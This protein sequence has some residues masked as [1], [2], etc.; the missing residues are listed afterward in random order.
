MRGFFFIYPMKINGIHRGIT[1][2]RQ[3]LVRPLI[4]FISGLLCADFLADYASFLEYV[5]L[6]LLSILFAQSHLQFLNKT[7]VSCT[8]YASFFLLGVFVNASP[9]PSGSDIPEFKNYTLIIKQCSEAVYKGSGDELKSQFT[10]EA[11][12]ILIDKTWQAVDGIIKFTLKND[13]LT[14][15][16][17]DLLLVHA[18]FKKPTTEILPGS[19]DSER[20]CRIKSIDALCTLNKY[21]LIPLAKN[22]QHFVFAFILNLRRAIIRYLKTS[23]FDSNQVG[24]ASALLVGYRADID[25][26]LNNAYSKA[27]IIHVLAVSGMHVSLVFGSVLWLLGRFLKPRNAAIAGILVLWFYALLAGLSASVLRSACMFSLLAISK[28]LVK[29]AITSNAMAGAA[30]IMLI[31]DPQTLYDPGAQLSF[32]AVWGIYARATP[33]PILFFKRKFIRYVID[34]L[35]IC[36]VAQLATLPITFWYFG[37]F[38]VYFLLANLVAVPFS[39][40]LIYLGFISLILFPLGFVSQQLLELMKIGIDILNYFTLQIAGLPLSSID[41]GRFTFIEVLFSGCIIYTM[42]FPMGSLIKK[43]YA[44]GIARLIYSATIIL[45]SIRIDKGPDLY[46]F[47]CERTYHFVSVGTRSVRLINIGSEQCHTCNRT[48]GIKQFAQ[49][50]GRDLK[51]ENHTIHNLEDGGKASITYIFDNTVHTL[52]LQIYSTCNL[53]NLPSTDKSSHAYCRQFN[54]SQKI[55]FLYS[56]ILRRRVLPI[57]FL[58][59]YKIR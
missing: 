45:T 57:G 47:S 10:A 32:A 50:E 20:F 14:S 17:G 54:S 55:P 39:T 40:G 16:P 33:P 49:K 51:I 56:A 41:F 18:N 43:V 42:L 13:S 35:W 6:V 28:L 59:S 3:P 58:N 19:F 1:W 46:F 22:E 5:L 9:C 7:L 38:P 30:F 52:T 34:S 12:S 24:I 25:A 11:K 8:L 15:I 21:Q 48:N 53:A 2:N 37:S 44:I 23:G 31:V 29:S 4:L 36:M 27:G 26:E